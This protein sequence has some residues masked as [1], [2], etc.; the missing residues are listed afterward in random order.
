M[1]VNK[2]SGGMWNE[3][4]IVYFKVSWY[5]PGKPQIIEGL[6]FRSLSEI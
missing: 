4:G 3:P 1:I 2:E 6:V 5:L